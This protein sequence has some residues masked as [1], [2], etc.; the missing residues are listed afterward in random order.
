[1]PTNKVSAFSFRYLSLNFFF[2]FPPNTAAHKLSP[3][4]TFAV[5]SR[6]VSCPMETIASGYSVLT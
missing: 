3:C 6:S 5:Q 1:M 4:N 2:F